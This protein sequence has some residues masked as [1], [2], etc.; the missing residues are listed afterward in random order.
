MKIV[1]PQRD[2]E[3]PYTQRQLIEAIKALNCN[4]KC[5]VLPASDDAM[6]R[7]AAYQ[8]RAER[9]HSSGGGGHGHTNLP[10]DRSFDELRESMTN[11]EW[12]HSMFKGMEK[13]EA[14]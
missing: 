7:A 1:T 11:Y 5:N 4:G 14:G 13:S 12:Q 9:Q 6:A 8:A 3:H 10:A 2:T